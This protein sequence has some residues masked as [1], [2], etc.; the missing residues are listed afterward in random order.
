MEGASVMAKVIFNCSHGQEDPERATLP[1]VAA[2]VAAT[3][4]QDA[5]VLLTVEG[6]WLCTKGYSDSIKK[7]GFPDLQP[8][9]M[10]FVENGGQIW[11]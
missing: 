4:G 3:A 9:M 5:I 2:N 11:G 10:E 7:D 8:L 6:A 1:F